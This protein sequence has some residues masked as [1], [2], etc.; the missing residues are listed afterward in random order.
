MSEP[1]T[2]ELNE[3]SNAVTD[4]LEQ[5]TATKQDTSSKDDDILESAA[6]ELDE[7]S[8]SDPPEPA[9]KSS[10]ETS[11]ENKPNEA[12]KTPKF[13]SNFMTSNLPPISK[14]KLVFLGDLSVGKTSLI[15]RFM[16][17]SFDNEYVATVGIDFLSKTIHLENRTLRLQI[18]DTAGQE[19]FRT[20]IPAYIR[21]SAAAV[22][23]FDIS[24]KESFKNSSKWINDARNERNGDIL[25]YLVGNKADVDESKRA[26]SESEI[27][28]FVEKEEANE[29]SGSGGKIIYFETS[30]SNG[31]NVKNLFHGIATKLAEN[32]ENEN[33]KKLVNLEAKNQSNSGSTQKSKVQLNNQEVQESNCNC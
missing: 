13:P 27:K 24:D 4:V 10:T 2:S 33:E 32:E 17:D 12:A 9:T 6:A 25:I 21:D 18:W 30:A 23:V 19:R 26:V 1:E 15:S 22:I 29:G 31:Y 7:T 16:F 3:E 14:F 8:I 28:E 20:L 5:S 11:T